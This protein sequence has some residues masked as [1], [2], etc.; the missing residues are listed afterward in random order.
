[1]K[2][3]TSN[4]NPKLNNKISTRILDHPFTDYWDI[5]VLKHQHPI[6]IFLH[7]IGIFFFYSLLLIIW[8]LHNYWLIFG[9]PITQL[10]GLAGHFLFERSH[11]D[12]QDA[13]FSWRASFCLGKLLFRVLLG[14]YGEDIRQRQEI[15][16][17][18]HLKVN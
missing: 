4:F 11:I 5:F 14:K 15:L 1:M 9:L 16:Q 6:N 13:V 12:L 17:Q 3:I 10:I 7:I 8:K 2:F 18:Y